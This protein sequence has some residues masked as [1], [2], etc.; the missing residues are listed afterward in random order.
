MRVYINISIYMCVCVVPHLIHFDTCLSMLIHVRITNADDCGILSEAA[1]VSRTEWPNPSSIAA[2][3]FS[4]SASAG[5]RAAQFAKRAVPK[6][7]ACIY[8]RIYK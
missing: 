2:R 5:K 4:R 1:T 7:A 6:E 8:M 3:T